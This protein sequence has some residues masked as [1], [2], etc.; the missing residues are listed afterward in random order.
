MAVLVIGSF[1]IDLVATVKKLPT[2]GE[3]VIGSRFDT[4][5]G[6]KGANQAIAARRLGSETIMSGMLGD[7]T[8]GQQFLALLKRENIDTEHIYQCKEPTGRGLIT[9]DQHGNNRIVI[10]PSANMQY[11]VKAISKLKPVIQ[12]ADVTLVQLEIPMHVTEAIAKSVEASKGILILNPAPAAKLSNK[13]LKQVDFLTPNETELAFLSKRTIQTRDDAFQAAKTLISQGVKAV[14]TTLGADGALYVDAQQAFHVSGFSVS[15]KDTVAAGD[16]FNGALAHMIEQ[17]NTLK[18]SLL[19]ANAVGALSVQKQ[20]AIPSL[21]SL[22][23]VAQFL[24]K[25]TT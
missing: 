5:F 20:G 9:V 12:K 15:V 11:P 17:G 3:T 23:D 10:I 21:P 22:E 24:V 14:V 2:T 6:G 1:M 19:F 7:D 13:L 18:E 8:Q 4:F 16:A 25:Q